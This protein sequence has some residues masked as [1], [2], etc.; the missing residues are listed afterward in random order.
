MLKQGWS[1]LYHVPLYYAYIKQ[2]GADGRARRMAIETAAR[3]A[4]TG[5]A[6]PLARRSRVYKG[7]TKFPQ[8]MYREVKTNRRVAR[9]IVEYGRRTPGFLTN[10]S[11]PRNS[12]CQRQ[13]N[14]N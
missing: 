5:N 14:N 8:K 4:I 13:K 3:E 9:M 11:L 1:L 10:K 12:R 2:P 6:D 7:S